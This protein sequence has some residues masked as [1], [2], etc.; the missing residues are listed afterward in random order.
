MRHLIM[1]LTLVLPCVAFAADTIEATTVFQSGEGG[2]H[3]YRIPAALVTP[4]G[5]VLAFCEGRSAVSDHAEN[6]I[7][8]KRSTD[9]G[10]TWSALTVVAEDG[11]NCLNNPCV[12]TDRSNGRILLMFQRYPE[13]YDERTV[14]PGLEGDKIVRTWLMYSDDNGKTW[15]APR[16]VTQNTKPANAT[17]VASGP[18]NGI[19]LR[20]GAFAGRILFPF[21]HGPYGSWKVYSVLSDD[22]G[23]TWTYGIPAVEGTPGHA[24]EVQFVEMVTG[25]VRLNARS[26]GGAKLRKTTLS[27]DSGLSW[28]VPL[29]DVP[30]LPDPSCMGSMIRYGDPMDGE[31][32]TLLFSG[33]NSQDKRVDGTIWVSYDEGQ[34]WSNPQL[35]HEGHF[36]YSHLVRLP[37]GNV[38]CLYETGNAGPYERIDFARVSPDWLEKP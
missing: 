3:T 32:P 34:G 12:V 37:D 13:A 9:Q 19:Q 6:D 11:D 29:M 7:V 10:K 27:I 24:N 26:F 16:D 36:A 22:G 8:M 30:D 20:R 23:E 31:K 2:Y 38:G 15:S 21:N 1:L 17:S 33:P 5:D 25:F 35:V 28:T 18:G 14:E 4:S